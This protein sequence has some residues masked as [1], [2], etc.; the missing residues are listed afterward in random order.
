[1][2][3][4]EPSNAEPLEIEVEDPRVKLEEALERLVARAPLGDEHYAQ[5]SN[6]AGSRLDEFRRAWESLPVEERLDLVARLRAREEDDLRLDFNPIYH[7]AIED[8]EAPIRIAGIRSTIE[9]KSDWLFDRLMRMADKDPDTVVRA[10]AARALGPFASGVELGEWPEEE[11][12]E[13]EALL[14]RLIR[15]DVE[16]IEVRGAALESAGHLNRAD[17]ASEIDWAFREPGLRLD[18]IRAMGHSS[19][20]RWLSRLLAAAE[21]EDPEVRKAVAQASGEIPDQASVPA[22]VD[23]L[24]DDA[25]DVRL[26][27]IAALGELGGDEA[28]EGLFYA[29]EDKRPEV[30]EAA[31]LAL[32]E[33]DFYEDP[34]SL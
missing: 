34:L 14:L 16:P 24:D 4:D 13:L 9:D 21:D 1:M 12:D 33:L 23:M 26:A 8:R 29:I 3:M 18:A 6:L 7:L 10:T 5:L 31:S 20:P 28:R 11:A 30:R 32:A 22:L 25:V 17:V 27:A 15:R 19:E 2:T